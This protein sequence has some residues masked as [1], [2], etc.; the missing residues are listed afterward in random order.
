MKEQTRVVREY[1]SLS[2]RVNVVSG[3]IAAL[4]DHL[5][6]FLSHM[7]SLDNTKKVK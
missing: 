2:S 6:E 5:E 1:S 3:K 4:A 7:L